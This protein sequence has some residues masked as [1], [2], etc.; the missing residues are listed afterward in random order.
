MMAEQLI[1][2]GLNLLIVLALPLAVGYLGKRRGWFTSQQLDPLIKF[3][4]YVLA[5][6]TTIASL[7]IV[8]MG[9]ELLL[10][11]IF[12][13]VMQVV[14][15]GAALF[16]TLRRRH[17]LRDASSYLLA[18]ALMNRG[19]VSAVTVFF[20][21]GETG[22]GYARMI[23]LFGPIVLFGMVFPVAGF[24]QHRLDGGDHDQRPSIGQ[25]VRKGL[26]SFNQMPTVG[27]IIGL[28]LNGADVQRPE[29][30]A[31]AFPYLMGVLM[32]LVILPL[33]AALRFRDVGRYWKAA[34][35]ISAMRFV[36]AP[37]ITALLALPFL[38]GEPFWVTVI[39]AGAPCAI[40]SVVTSRLFGFNERLNMAAFV[41]STTVYLLILLPLT[42]V[43]G[44][45]AQ[46]S[47]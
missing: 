46:A 23:M 36:V 8:P 41:V 30:I 31:A 40:L 2:V 17:S 38:M 27:V 14:P 47:G 3:V 21:F 16:V 39:S 10:L 4:I 44:N 19:V 37:G 1:R 43:L 7:W 28:M 18:T 11:G 29:W 5:P 20:L 35:E 13:V 32:W 42:L 34:M 45:I 12:G 33:G 25:S 26:I 6:L 22:Y 24:V 15:G 9:G